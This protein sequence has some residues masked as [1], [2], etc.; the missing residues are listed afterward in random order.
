MNVVAKFEKVSID[1]FLKAFPIESSVDK[2]TCESMWND[3]TLPRRGT[4]ESAGYDFKSPYDFI[5][6]PGET[7]KIPTG[8]KACIDMGW[9]L[10]ILP[11]SSMGFKYRLQLDNTMGIIDSD[12]YNNPDNEGH[13]FIKVTN[14]SKTNKTLMIKAGESFAQGIFIPYG[15]TCDDNPVKDFRVGGIGSTGK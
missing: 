7:I 4:V 2:D 1:E 11:R 8:I 14:D 12:Y 6:A 10:G 9:F 13:I 15:I 3:I 5:L